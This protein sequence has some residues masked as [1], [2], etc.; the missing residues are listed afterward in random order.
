MEAGRKLVSGFLKPL[1]VSGFLKPLK[2]GSL[3][4]PLT[5]MAAPS[6]GQSK[7]IQ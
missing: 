3:E 6:R 5:A 7:A 1:S 4:L 2:E